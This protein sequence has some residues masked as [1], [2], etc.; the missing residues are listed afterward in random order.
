MATYTV[1]NGGGNINSAATYTPNTGLTPGAADTINFT[2]TSGQLTVNTTTTI[3]DIDFSNYT[4][5]ITFDSVLNVSRNI[6]FGDAGGNATYTVTTNVNGD[7]RKTGTGNITSNNK[8]WAGKFTLPNGTY[9]VTFMDKMTVSGAV[10]FSST[11]VVTLSPNNVLDPER[12]DVQG[13]FTVSATNATLTGTALIKFTGTANQS[14]SWTSSTGVVRNDIKVD[15][16]GGTLTLSGT[17]AYNTGTFTYVQGTVNSGSS[18]LSIATAT[19]TMNTNGSTTSGATTTSSTGINWNNVTLYTTLNLTSNFTCVGTLTSGVC[20]ITRAASENVYLGGSLTMSGTITSTA[21]AIIMNGTGTWSGSS[22]LIAPLTIDTSGT[23]TISGAVFFSTRTLTYTA[24]TVTTTGS[25]LTISASCTLATNGITWNNFTTSTTATITLTNNFSMSGVWTSRAGTITFAGA[26]TFNSTGSISFS[27]T[28]AVT[29]KN[30]LPN[31]TTITISNNATTTLAGDITASGLVTLGVTSS[32]TIISSTGGARTITCSAGLTIGSTTGFV[33][34][35]VNLK[36]TGGTISSS[37]SLSG[38]YI[39]INST[40]QFEIDGN[41]TF[42]AANALYMYGGVTTGTGGTFKYTSGTVTTTGSS[43]YVQAM[44]FNSG[45]IAWNNVWFI[46]GSASTTVLQS[47]ITV[48]GLLTLGYLTVSYTINNDGTTKTIAANGGITMSGSTSIVSGTA[49]IRATGGTITGVSSVQLRNNLEIVGNV[50]FASGV[51]F[52]YNT[53]ILLYTSG[54]VTTTNS[55]LSVGASTTLNTNGITW[56]NLTTSAT[57]VITLSSNFTWSNIWSSTSGTV[58]FTGAGLLVS[59]GS[60]SFTSSAAVT[61]PNS[62][63]S[64]TTITITSNAT[65]TLAG[66][67]SCSGLLTLGITTSG[68]TLSSSGGART[69]TT[70]GGLTTTT[71][72]GFVVCNVNVSVTGGT[73]TSSGSLSGGYYQFNTGYQFEIAGNVT[74]SASTFYIYGGVSTGTGGT[75]KYT[76]GT[77]TTTGSSIWI[78]SVFFNP[79]SIGWNNVWFISGSASTTVLQSNV[80]VNGLLTLGYLTVS[81]TINNDG[82]TRTITAN[83]GITM[84]GSTSVVSGTANIVVTGGTITGV[85]S[86]Q[87]RNNLTLNSAGTITFASGVTF[88]YNTGTLTYTAGTIVTTGSTLSVAASTTFATNGITWNIINWSGGT[89]TLSNVFTASGLITASHQTPVINGSDLYANGGMTFT[90]INSSASFAF[91]SGTST[92]R[93]EGTGAWTSTQQGTYR[94]NIIINPTTSSFT[95]SIYY[96]LGTITYSSA[97]GGTVTS[98]TVILGYHTAT[99]SIGLTRSA[100]FDTNTMRWDTVYVQNY[101]NTGTVTTTLTLNSNLNVNT[102][103]ATSIGNAANDILNFTMAEAANL[104]NVGTFNQDC[105]F[106]IN[107]SKDFTCKTLS[108]STGVFGRLNNN[109]ITVTDLLTS[110]ATAS[111]ITWTGT[112]KIVLGNNCTWSRTSDTGPIS[113]NMEFQGNL[114]LGSTAFPLMTFNASTLTYTGRKNAKVLGRLAI[115]TATMTNM[116][117]VTFQSLTITSGAT[118]TMNQFFGG[119]PDLKSTIV[120]SST[121]NYTI[122]FSDALEKIARYVNVTRATVSR[123]G[124]L[125]IITPYANGGNNVGIKFAP[126]QINNGISKNLPANDI[127]LGFVAQGLVKDPLLSFN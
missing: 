21:A 22:A 5:V 103:F 108:F 9:T 124:Q 42:A 40:Y 50:T 120:P 102:F 115:G 46:S 79:G 7:F 98:A 43:I 72:T 81:Y 88:G 44:N 28:A 111:N 64:L 26:G 35:N 119:S 82:T 19:T 127:Q 105:R 6:T 55:T 58:T 34:C 30:A 60:I 41:V 14:V 96:A 95:I 70:A 49:N 89:W 24:G 87:L 74:F 85:S 99:S 73:I 11:G 112:A 62:L 4:N 117:K 3:L 20:T 23:I 122:S 52:N 116:H 93:F 114:T 16:T 80:T 15:K 47:N 125:A 39:Q 78:H 97:N 84:S 69:I 13:D 90:G 61:I 126:N 109:T 48:N 83:N 106:T 63:L 51:T 92:I 86:T 76:S 31:I 12:F 71:T 67:I 32:S 75:F 45:S 54:A 37:G 100:T 121:T 94:N 18:T 123:A 53:G 107:L 104:V 101:T 57:A 91:I 29:T 25:T 38:G 77:V 110:Q 66:N 33:A 68:T 2:A 27:S 65:T 118:V 36:I 10:L 113:F 1:A 8:V 56:H 59:T 17:I